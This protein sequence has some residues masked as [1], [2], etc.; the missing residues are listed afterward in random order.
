MGATLQ[1][2]PEPIFWLQEVVPAKYCSACMVTLIGVWCVAFAAGWEKI[3]SGSWD[4][5]VMIWEWETSESPAQVLGHKNRVTGVAVNSDGGHIFSCSEDS[6]LT[7]W[8][9]STGKLT[10]KI[11]QGNAVDCVA[12]CGE[13]GM[14]AVGLDDGTLRVLDCVKKNVLFEHNEAHEQDICCVSFSLNGS[15]VAT[16]VIGRNDSCVEH[17]NMGKSW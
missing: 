14:I 13:N 1:L 9:I 8:D 7:I 15:Y 12:V 2:E 4:G 5:K 10:Q 11:S 16:G 17:W 3:V 6:T